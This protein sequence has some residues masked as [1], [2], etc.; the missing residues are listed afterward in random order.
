MRVL[1][2]RVAP[3]SWSSAAERRAP[4]SRIHLAR[5]A[6]QR[7]TEVD[8]VLV[9]PADRPGRGTA[10]G[11]TDDEHLLNVPAAGMTALPQDPGHF[12]AWRARQ[13]HGTAA[14][15]GTFAPRRQ[16]AP[17][18]RRD[19]RR[20]L[21]HGRRRP[22]RCATSAPGP[23][24][25]DA[26]RAGPR[27]AGR[28]A[29]AHRRRGRR[30]HRSARRRVTPGRRTRLH[31]LGLLRR[32]TRGR[33][34]PSTSY[35]AIAAG[36]G[37]VLLVGAGLTMVDV[38]L[39]LTRP[40][41]RAD[42][43]VLA[44]SRTGELPGHRTPTSSSWPPSPTSTTGAPTLAGL[45]ASVAEHVERVR[46]TGGDWRPA[47]D[48]LRF[49][50]SELW[51]RLSEDDRVEFLADR[52]QRLEPRPA[53]HAARARR[54]CC[55]SW[56]TADRLRQRTGSV[57][58]AAPLTERRAAGDPRPTARPTTSAGW[59][60]APAPPS[61]YDASATRCSTTCSRARGGVSLAQ[62]ATAGM[63]FR[64]RDGR[65]LDSTGR[66]DAPVWTLGALRRGRALGVHRG[67]RDPQPGARPGG[68]RAR[69][70]R[71]DAAPPRGR[72][73]RQRPPPRRPSA[74][75]ARPAAVGHRRGR[76][77]LQRRPRAGDAPPVRRRGP[78]PRGG[79]RSTPTSRSPTP[80]W[81]CSATRRAPSTD[82]AALA[83]RP[84]A[85]PSSSA[86]TSASAASSTSSAAGSTTPGTGAPRR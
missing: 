79:R 18:P 27:S 23:S 37:D 68:R 44:V 55:A 6:H 78:A 70:G 17:L 54:R 4:W 21:R 38:V 43:R 46:A 12:V 34:A 76:V 82:V 7:G 16:Y 25:Y 19:P 49:R 71:P 80:R 26:T 3:R 2:G 83:C 61:T 85:A 66:A 58:D 53:P 29:R 51:Q 57:V 67:A 28:R 39:S 5:T 33:P 81:R 11:T 74:R 60:T 9:D 41:G 64:T 48:G 8:V 42:R 1:R 32:R 15:P 45:R 69:R 10:F 35:A 84:R 13:E 20:R 65:L 75:P 40:G 62:A 22:P 36:P 86:A 77:A 56:P 31:R 24:A 52:R 72:P 59:S 50:V 47:M 14:E 73:S 30:R 63:G